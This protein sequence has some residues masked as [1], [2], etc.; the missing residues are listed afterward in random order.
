LV[1]VAVAV[2][3]LLVALEAEVVVGVALFMWVL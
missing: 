1:V 3:P 2:N